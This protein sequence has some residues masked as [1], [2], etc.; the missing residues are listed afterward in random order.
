M[1]NAPFCNVEIARPPGKPQSPTGLTP[2]PANAS[3]Q[4]AIRIINNNFNQL[5]KGN[6]V[7]NRAARQVTLTR[8]FDPADHNVF[9]DVRQITGV[10]FVNPLTGQ[11][12]VWQ[13]GQTQQP[14]QPGSQVSVQTGG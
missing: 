9:V 6:F 4:Q 7:E 8:I 2:I 1:A 12:I 3:L 5:I 11:T 13:R 10:F 14:A